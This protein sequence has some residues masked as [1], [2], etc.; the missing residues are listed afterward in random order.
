MP[1][2]GINRSCH[3]LVLEE[4]ITWYSIMELLTHEA[5][6]RQ[7]VG[8]YVRRDNNVNTVESF[9]QTFQIASA[10]HISES[11]N[12]MCQIH[13]ALGTNCSAAEWDVNLP[14]AEVALRCQ[15]MV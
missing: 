12:P 10:W 6:S 7:C 4:A 3:V 1:L 9:P 8:L 2:E 5:G 14:A 11:R 13:D 15:S